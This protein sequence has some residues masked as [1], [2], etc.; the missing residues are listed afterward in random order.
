M[1]SAARVT[2]GM[3]ILKTYTEKLIDVKQQ[4]RSAKVLLLG[5]A[6]GGPN[7]SSNKN[8]GK[9]NKKTAATT[10]N[11]QDDYSSF[12]RQPSNVGNPELTTVKS[13]RQAG[14][15]QIQHFI[16][17]EGDPVYKADR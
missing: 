3:H 7:P 12:Q 8:R 5:D 2:A 13:H 6:T 10:T 4:V 1:I 15:C 17:P 16:P 14:C 9:S 11:L